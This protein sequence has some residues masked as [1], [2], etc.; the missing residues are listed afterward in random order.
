MQKNTG[1]TFSLIAQDA[2]AAMAF[3]LKKGII[4]LIGNSMVT[5]KTQL[6]HLLFWL[7]LGLMGQMFVIHSLR[8]E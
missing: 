4:T 3:G 2:N 8:M 7:G 6:F 1:Q 5:L